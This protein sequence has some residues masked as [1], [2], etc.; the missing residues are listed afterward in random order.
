MLHVAQFITLFAAVVA[1]LLPTGLAAYFYKDRVGLGRVLAW[2]Y[3][4]SAIDMAL[5]AVFAYSSYGQI[6]LGLGAWT[7]V[8]MRMTMITIALYANIKAL[9][10]VL[11]YRAQ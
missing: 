11:A 9:R 7:V 1:T 10:Y 3:L 5:V 6:Y 8:G 4:S 2:L